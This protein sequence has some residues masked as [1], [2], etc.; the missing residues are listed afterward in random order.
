MILI[1]I[2]TLGVA[3]LTVVQY[4]IML[5]VMIVTERSQV[6]PVVPASDPD[7]SANGPA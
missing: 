4:P 1:Y 7:P 2:G 5:A 6:L 3:A